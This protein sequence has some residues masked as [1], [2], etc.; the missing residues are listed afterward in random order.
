MDQDQQQDAWIDSVLAQSGVPQA[1]TEGSAPGPVTDGTTPGQADTGTV[2]PSGEQQGTESSPIADTTAATPAVPD[3]TEARFAAMQAQLDE[4]SR[5][6]AVL[7]Q[8]EQAARMQAEQQARD[9]Q[10][11]EWQRQMEDAA[12]L[13]PEMQQ[14]EALRIMA[15]IRQSEAATYEPQL[16]QAQSDVEQAAAVATAFYHAVQNNPQIPDNVKEQIFAD[17]RFL[18]NLPS[19]DAQKQTLDRDRRIAESA[20]AQYRAQLEKQND[21][22]IATRANERIEQGTD[23]VGTTAGSVGDG[24]DGSVDFLVDRVFGNRR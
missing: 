20:I 1:A 10:I 23:L 24:D 18:A 6:A 11:A 12:E 2:A 13:T 5:K 7:D 8:I 14:R 21:T 19:P 9:K 15:E 17:S 3:P 16:F 22:A 4:A